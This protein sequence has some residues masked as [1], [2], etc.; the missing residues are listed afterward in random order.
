MELLTGGLSDP[1]ET[2]AVA[3]LDADEVWY[4][5]KALKERGDVLAVSTFSDEHYKENG[6]EYT[7]GE[8]TAGEGLLACGLVGGHGEQ[9]PAASSLCSPRRVCQVPSLVECRCR[10]TP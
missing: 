4:K 6:F 10:P 5:V 7:E 3:E 8:G 2:L 9:S 1:R